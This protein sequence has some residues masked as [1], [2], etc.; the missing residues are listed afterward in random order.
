MDEKTQR[1]DLR[2]NLI[3]FGFFVLI[4]LGGYLGFVQ[5]R[6]ELL[7]EQITISAAKT[8]AL[9]KRIDQWLVTRKTEVSTLAN[10]PVIRSMDWA[11]AGPFLKAKHEQ[12]PWFYI[13]AHINP[14]GTYYNSKVDFAKGQNLSDRAHFRAAM[15]GR[16]YASDPVN[17]RTLSADIVAVTSPIWATDAKGA[18]IIGVF[19]GMIDSS[20]IVQEL[21]KF[22]NGPGSYAFAINSTGVAIAHPDPKRRGNINTNAVSLAKDG[23]PGLKAVAEQ[24]LSGRSGW[25]R[26]T[27]DGQDVYAHFTPISEAK[28]FIAT[29]TRADHLHK[30]LRFVDAMGVVGLLVLCAVVALVVRYRRLELRTLSQQREVAE[31]KNRA[32]SVFLAN[33][34]HELR[35]PLNGILGYSQILMQ[36]TG[37]DE[38]TRR[39]LGII[40]S[41]GQHLLSL[42]NR[43]LD[44]SK[45][46]AGRIELEP[47]PVDLPNLMQ[48][49]ARLF[50]IEKA[51]Y[52]A[53]LR[54]TIAPDLARVA[55]LDADKL[56]QIVTNVVV[57]AFKY[58]DRSEVRLDVSQATENGRPWLRIEVADGGR[59]MTPQQLQRAFVPF[60]QVDKTAEGVGLG[61]AIVKQLLDL[62]GGSVAI[63][64][65][66]GRGT[67]VR[68]SVPFEVA[69]AGL[70]TALAGERGLPVAV[71]Q[72]RPRILVV[73]DNPTNVQMLVELL[74]LSGFEARGC[75]GVD[76]ALAV[77][78]A[79]AFDL[80]VTDLVMP[81]RDGFDLIR[82]I[83]GGARAAQTPIIVASASAYPGDQVRSTAAGA[84]DFLA[85][86]VDGAALLQ[87]IAALL[88]LDYV[89]A[90][91][92]GA[93]PASAQPAGDADLALLRGE[94]A[95]PVV[96]RIRQAAELGQLMRVESLVGEVADPALGQALHRLLDEGLREQ[97]P[98]LLLKAIDRVAGP[99]SS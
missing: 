90:A 52:G 18:G 29:V 74:H 2:F 53:P 7:N 42:I 59:G 10:T 39:Q 63:D 57:N 37:L 31:E 4:G 46:E 51:K 92:A 67:R 95:R 49:L 76:E 88:R 65:E 19:G 89:Y 23:D 56:K 78:G 17:S 25:L 15:E 3:L 40:Q 77:F 99:A 1:V 64:S 38:G 85:K 70:A 72:G 79:E 43:I 13:F 45:I 34:S 24:M 21:A 9:A 62:M 20:T 32:K 93:L 12:M 35:T 55:V 83:R 48:D 28:W 97:D 50:D 91:E 47:R 80:V 44:L 73:D 36:R 66:P 58:G 60:E 22:A 6:N 61:L 68:L 94:P 11:Q 27:V 14:D 75:A 86:P 87:K 81:G 5:I 26:T 41:S 16:V 98:D 69:D 8:D 82:A 30:N 54:W 33:M 84:N 96:Q 71:R